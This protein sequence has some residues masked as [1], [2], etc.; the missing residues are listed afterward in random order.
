M[1]LPCP[2]REKSCA[3]LQRLFPSVESGPGKGLTQQDPNKRGLQLPAAVPDVDCGDRAED[4]GFRSPG[5]LC[6][7]C[8]QFP[9]VDGASDFR[10]TGNFGKQVRSGAQG[11]EG[12]AQNREELMQGPW[13][14]QG[15]QLRK[16]LTGATPVFLVVPERLQKCSSEPS[17]PGPNLLNYDNSTEEVSEI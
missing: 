15:R 1:L 13:E 17:V 10:Q 3:H 5:G 4:R 11:K 9:H 16:G 7:H 12:R 8:W 6:P 2:G 14:R